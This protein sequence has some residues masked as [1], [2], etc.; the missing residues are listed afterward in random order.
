MIVFGLGCFFLHFG[1][2]VEDLSN[3]LNIALRLLFYLT[4]VFWNIMDRL[5]A[6]FNSYVGKGNP[7]AFLLTAMRDCVLYEKTPDLPLLFGWFLFGLVISILG[8]RLL[9][10]NENSYV[11]VI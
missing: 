3:V 4:G 7:I 11:K 6:P 1:V 5:P 10:R 2:F 8:V 9:Y